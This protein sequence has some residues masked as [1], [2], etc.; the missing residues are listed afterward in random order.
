MNYSGA[1]PALALILTRTDTTTVGTPTTAG[2]SLIKAVDKASALP[3]E[4]LTYTITYSNNSS[5]V[6]NNVVIS[7]S[8]PAFTAYVGASAGCPLV[9]VR[10]SCTVTSEPANNTT[11]SIQWNITGSFAPGVSATVQFRVQVQ[12]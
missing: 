5:G 3:G 11:G 12:Q 2:L 9:V 4:I 8:T 7:D 1:S 10:T 6:L